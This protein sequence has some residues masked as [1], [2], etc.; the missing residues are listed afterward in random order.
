MSGLLLLVL[1]DLPLTHGLQ[2]GLS[3]AVAQGHN[4]SRVPLGLLDWI[5]IFLHSVALLRGRWRRRRRAGVGFGGHQELVAGGWSVSKGALRLQLRQLL[6]AAAA[7]V[8][9]FIQLQAFAVVQAV[10][11]K[12]LRPL[13]IPLQLIY[14]NKCPIRSDFP[15]VY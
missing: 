6:L 12:Y 2:G 15:R 14:F 7:T 13:Q 4:R 3:L 10:F 1:G 11:N 8:V 5:P 9:Q